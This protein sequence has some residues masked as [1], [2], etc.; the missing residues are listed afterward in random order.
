MNIQNYLENLIKNKA[1]YVLSKEDIKK[2]K[3]EGV[4]K[5]IFSKLSSSKYKASSIS[6]ELKEGTIK[7][8][9]YCVENNKPIHVT[10][11][12][13]GYKKWQLPTAPLPDWS[14]VF[15]L[16]YLREH[17][18]PICNAY[19]PGVMLEYFSDE[20]FV[21]RMNNIPQEDLDK[22]NQGFTELIE[23]LQDYFPP[24]FQIKYSKIRD[25]ISQEELMKSFNKDIP[26]LRQK[27]EN[28]TKEEQEY[29]LKKAERNYKGG[30]QYLSSEEKRTIL[31]DSSLVHD[32]FIFG[33]WDK[34]IPWA[35]DKDMI[36]VGFRY[37]GSWGIHIR[38]SWSS[39]VQF[40]VGIGVLKIKENK[41]IPSILTFEQYQRI[42]S[43]LRTETVQIFPKRFTNLTKILVI[44]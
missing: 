29:R 35:F 11:P 37:T 38:S 36:P 12:F 15:N 5:Y 9:H 22:Y 24:N 19:E 16:I 10:I 32:A 40:W 8:I 23:F 2:I 39:T 31:L 25:F 6:E 3:F 30:L 17:L 26:E 1:S 14:E 34:N 33:D 20:I 43:N 28:L 27:F 21:S 41:I 44:L 18:T 4:E 13:G 7:K 42:S